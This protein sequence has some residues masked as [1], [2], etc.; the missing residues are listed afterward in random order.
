MLKNIVLLIFTLVIL[1][2][3]S[4]MD[5]SNTIDQRKA[6]LDAVED[7]CFYAYYEFF[8]GQDILICYK[9]GSTIKASSKKNVDAQPLKEEREPSNE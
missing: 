4:S 1:S 3:C 9:D 8:R 2:N 7:E 6:E 5:V